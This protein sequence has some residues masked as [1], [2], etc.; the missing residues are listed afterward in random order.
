V[1]GWKNIYHANEHEKKARVAILM[2]DKLDFKSKTITRDE[3]HYIIIKGTIQPEDLTIVNIYA[4]NL[5]SP[6][7][8]RQLITNIK[9]L[10]DN[11]T[12]I[13]GDFNTPLISI[14]HLS[15][16]STREQWP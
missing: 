3:E 8:I 14:D 9:E 4:P 16:K 7:Y 2:S 6:I 10:I 5:G 12:I 1:R 15:R 13:V 11:N